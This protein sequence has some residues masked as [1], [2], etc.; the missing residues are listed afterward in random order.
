MEDPTPKPHPK[1][2]PG[3]FYVVD[4]C[5]TACGVPFSEAP[6]LFAYDETN[7][8]FVKRQPST[9]R[10]FDQAFRAAWA[11]EL[12]CIRYCGDDPQMLRRFAEVGEPHLCDV[13]P[14]AHVSP[15]VRDVVLFDAASP[16]AADLTALELAQ[17]YRAHCLADQRAQADVEERFRFRVTDVAGDASLASL[18]V[19]W[20]EDDFHAVEFR[21]FATPAS[22]WQIRHFST[23]RE[24]GRGLSNKI[25]DWLKGYGHFA[26][27]RWYSSKEHANSADFRETPV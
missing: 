15:I 6:G 14:P 10:E 3:P 16:S 23:D 1:N 17:T 22:R 12:Q 9:Q 11:A 26:D 19:A 20:Y 13:P 21:L 8:C 5:C 24:G 7:H 4:Q 18:S 27:I 2:V 25:D